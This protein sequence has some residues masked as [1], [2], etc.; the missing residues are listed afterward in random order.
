MGTILTESNTFT[1]TIEVPNPFEP[2]SAADPLGSY[3]VKGT[4]S[5]DGDLIFSGATNQN[6][7]V[8]TLG[9][10]SMMP[11]VSV[12]GNDITLQLA[13]NGVGTP[14]ST[15]SAMSALFMGTPAAVAL[16]TCTAGGTGLGIC[17]IL[18]G[19]MPIGKD[20][21]GSI[22][23]SIQALTNRTRYTGTQVDG[24][25][26]GTKTLKSVY[27]DG[28]GD[29]PAPLAATPGT[30]FSSGNMIGDNNVTA[31]NN[32]VSLIGNVNA[33]SGAV[34][35]FTNVNA[36][37]GDVIAANEVKGDHLQVLAGYSSSTIPTSANALGKAGMGNILAG[38]IRVEHN[39]S[40][41]SDYT[42]KSAL[43]VVGFSKNLTAYTITFS[44]S[45]GHYFACMNMHAKPSS[46]T[47]GTLFYRYRQ[48]SMTPL[49]LEC[50]I[51]ISGI[52]SDLTEWGFDLLV[53]AE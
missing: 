3:R 16:A 20:P 32:L 17:G 51:G 44:F 52:G 40:G 41:V 11:S 13:T 18:P 10:I 30:I 25:L 45:P 14:T 48:I 39:G 46:A 29:Q 27:V 5:P 6:V 37:T 26:L 49:Q 42:I 50:I 15:A 12:V 23:P 38:A 21:L 8:I 35:A 2:V 47:S 19:F 36:V 28:I 43:N 24:I 33:A 31:K 22:R 1:P 4:T 9:G 53:F 34:N 7:R